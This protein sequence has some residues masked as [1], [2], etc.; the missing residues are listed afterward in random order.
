[1]VGFGPT[2]LLFPA[3]KNL[4]ATLA[5]RSPRTVRLLIIGGFFISFLIY[6]GLYR[7]LGH[8]GRA[9][10]LGPV[11]GPLIG[12]LL[13]AK[14]LEMLYMALFLMLIF[15]SIIS[16]FSV[17]Y[18]DDELAVLIAS[19][20]SIG[21]IFWSR[22]ALLVGESSWMV[23]AFFSPVFLAF[24]TAL[25]APF[26]AYLIL[27]LFILF[28][29]LIPNLVGAF[30]ALMLASAFP[31]R[32]MRRVFQFLSGIVLAAMVIF[33]RF[34]EPEKLIN[35]HYFSDVSRYL[36]SLRNP[37]FSWFPSSWIHQSTLLLFQGDLP[38]AVREFIPV[39]ALGVLF[40]VVLHILAKIYY[41][42][43]WQKSLEAVENQVRGLELLR[44]ILLIPLRHLPPDARA[45]ADKEVTV[46]FRD[47]A[48]FSQIFMMGAIVFVYGYNLTILPL[49]ELPSLYAGEINDSLVYFN[50][51]FIGFILA[52]IAMRFVYPSISI[53]GRAFW[54]VK[55]SPVPA[56]RLLQV[57]F[58]LYLPPIFALGMILCYISNQVF[59]VTYP[60]LF[61][62]SFFNVALMSV[63]IT[64]LAIGL[65]AIYARF[66]FDNPVKIAGSFGGFVFMVMSALFVLNLLVFQAYPMFRFYFHRFYPMQQGTYVLIG[67]AFFLLILSTVAWVVIP[68]R[69]GRE[70]IERYEPE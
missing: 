66:D 13:T 70:A 48:I 34:M 60:V 54:A 21:R 26:W 62:L 6:F 14:L 67:L 56:S 5:R 27:P 38:R 31:I 2:S 45:I 36:L 51:P 44:R 11:V 49:K 15:S 1:L 23:I 30:L 64:A 19:P 3:L 35:P 8:V 59:R 46:F 50:G 65:G 40:F 42:T 41:L 25:K 52:A 10:M 32:Q 4:Q 29:L 18:L 33:L 12:G 53:E 68:L 43:S 47:P 17:Y 39:F 58:W 7:F 16:A 20:V 69:K 9:P 63:V 24:A 57:K 22:F 55:S 61:W 28:Y 37:Y